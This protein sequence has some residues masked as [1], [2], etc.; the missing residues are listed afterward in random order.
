MSVNPLHYNSDALRVSSYVNEIIYHLNSNFKLRL[1]F[2]SDIMIVRQK[3]ILRKLLL[4]IGA[5]SGSTQMLYA[6][7]NAKPL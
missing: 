3:L 1:L 6:S 5:V 7:Q 2:D 4:V